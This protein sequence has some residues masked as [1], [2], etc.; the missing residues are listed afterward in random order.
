[1]AEEDDNENDDP[2]IL[3]GREPQAPVEE[4]EVIDFCKF[5][6][7]NAS[8]PTFITPVYEN[9]EKGPEFETLVP[10]VEREFGGHARVQRL[11]TEARLRGWMKDDSNEECAWVSFTREWTTQLAKEGRRT[12]PRNRPR[13]VT[14]AGTK[15]DM[16]NDANWEI[17]FAEMEDLIP[18]VERWLWLVKNA[19]TK[20]EKRG[21]DM[22]LQKILQLRGPELPDAIRRQ[23]ADAIRGENVG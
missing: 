10:K 8:D 21:A 12:R 17:G 5:V 16:R 11:W 23:V 7:Q 1:L 14:V 22:R 19:S 3:E 20:G 13:Q 6:Y 15:F 18:C 4:A 9:N 2:V